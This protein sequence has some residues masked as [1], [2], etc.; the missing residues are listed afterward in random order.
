[1][2]DVPLGVFLSGGL[3]SSSV[4]AMMIDLLPAQQTLKLLNYGTFPL[5]LVSKHLLVIR[6]LSVTLYIY[7]SKGPLQHHLLTKL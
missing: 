3:D 1:M 6:I 4:V 2:S 5:E 7:Q